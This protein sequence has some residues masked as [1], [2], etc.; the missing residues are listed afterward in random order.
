MVSAGDRGKGDLAFCRRSSRSRPSRW[1][2]AARTAALGR[3]TVAPVAFPISDHSLFGGESYYPTPFIGPGAAPARI[4][5]LMSAADPDLEVLTHD[6][7]VCNWLSSRIHFRIDDYPEL[8]G[9]I[10]LVAPDP[11]VRSVKQYFTRDKDQK[12]WLVTG[13]QPRTGQNLEGLELTILEE[14]FGAISTFLRPPIPSHGMIVTEAPSQ[15]RSSGYMLAH[16]ERGLIGFQP[17]VP[18]VRAVGIRMETQS[19]RVL[20]QTRDSKKKEAGVKIKTYEI[21]EFAHATDSLVGDV[22]PPMTPHARYYDAVERRAISRQ[23]WLH[24]QRWK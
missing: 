12:E 16:S 7:A 14:R 17:P 2:L 18:F 13:L 8:L 21:G 4:H 22:T 6:L 5:R 20:L 15:I 10:V 23:A 9:S 1:R 24:D 11:Q 3:T 19:R